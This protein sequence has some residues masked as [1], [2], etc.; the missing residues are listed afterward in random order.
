MTTAQDARMTA[1][2]LKG[3]LN[4]AKELIEPLGRFQNIAADRE[5]AELVEDAMK[6][7]NDAHDAWQLAVK[8][9]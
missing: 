6:Q 9:A 2:Q 5:A 7:L 1:L 3:A 8:K 4:V